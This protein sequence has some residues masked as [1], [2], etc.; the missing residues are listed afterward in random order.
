[1]NTFDDT[2][3]TR[4][5]HPRWT[6]LNWAGVWFIEAPGPSGRVSKEGIAATFDTYAQAIT[7]YN[8]G[9]RK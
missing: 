1:M 9:T 6:I 8:E 4:D 2:L 3:A 5:H 7:S